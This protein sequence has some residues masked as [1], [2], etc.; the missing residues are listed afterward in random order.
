M[1]H[2]ET[3]VLV[4]GGGATGA[5]V[6]RDAALRGFSAILVDR[7]DLAEGTTGRF[8]G[9]LHS[10]GRYVVKDA[11]SAK[12]CMDENRILRRIAADTIEDT[13]GL[14][15]QTPWDEPD[16]ADEFVLGCGVAGIPVE[17]IEPAQAL[18]EEPRL[19]PDISRAFR[20][21]DASID[22]W[23]LVWACARSAEER[24]AR[25]MTRHRVERLLKDGDAVTGAVA[26]NEL[27]GSEVTI[28]AGFVV[29]ASGAWAA[30]VAEMGGCEGITILPGKGIMIAMNH[31]LVNTVINRCGRPADGDI[32]VPIRTVSVIGTTDVK[33]EHPDDLPVTQ[34][35][36]D[37][38]LDDGEKLVPGFR[39]ARAL[40]VWA[41]VRPLFQDAKAE[42]ASTRDVSRSHAL[43]DHRERDG[44]DNFIT[45]T[46][47]KLTTF[48]RM[49]QD[50]VDAMCAQLEL[51]RPCTSAREPLPD[52]EDHD[53]YW[54]GARLAR[55]EETL[56]DDQLIC[57]CELISRGRLEDAMRR[58]NTS[59]LDD[60]RRS[61][62]LGMGPCQGG[63]CIYRATGILYGVEQLDRS[64]A[65]KALLDF[66]QERWKGVHPILYGDGLRQARFD[67]WVFQGLLDV[68][69]LP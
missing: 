67:E 16:Y 7:G 1:A 15:V 60:M 36:I 40:R 63:F 51:D 2:L 49:A 14:F 39:A 61:L 20:V 5:G 50:A 10:G 8:H 44:V 64:G 33:V 58:R 6:V 55:R 46:G 17:E 27:D 29:N 43:L 18:H 28:E 19:N 23:K 69:H 56:H 26:V 12:E 4:I 57:E 54:L 53:H 25:I 65:N 62:R 52:S 47:G 32:L 3:E 13:G 24:G 31:R 48:R 35:E 9:L 42:V 34:D 21:P 38:M 22:A 45:I 11:R 66:L 30:Q 37:Q 41:G 59:D 68:E